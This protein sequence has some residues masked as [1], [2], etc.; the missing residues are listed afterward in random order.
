MHAFTAGIHPYAVS[1]MWPGLPDTPMP[2]QS[3]DYSSTRPLPY[4]Q[5]RRV[6]AED[7]ASRFRHFAVTDRL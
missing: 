5:Q 4:R 6:K 2:D 7:H 3:D 1:D